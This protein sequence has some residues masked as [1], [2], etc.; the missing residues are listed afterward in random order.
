[1]KEQLQRA[2]KIANDCK[3]QAQAAKD[4]ESVWRTKC[5]ELLEENKSLK[6]QIPEP[7][8]K[9]LTPEEELAELKTQLEAKTVKVLQ[10]MAEELKL[11]LDEYKDFN[12]TKLI[13]YLISKTTNVN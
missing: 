6:A 7:K 1:L 10:G 8:P 13:E 11:P 12:K 9:V 5:E 4:G 2:N 3:I